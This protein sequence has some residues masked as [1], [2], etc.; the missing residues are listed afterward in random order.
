MDV[1][2]K[3][4]LIHKHWLRKGR[5][6]FGRRRYYENT[7]L[8]GAGELAKK[9]AKEHGDDYLLVQVIKEYSAKADKD[10]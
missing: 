2:G 3:Y 10:E 8:G 9:Y 1:Q 5:K 4:F 6:K 7:E